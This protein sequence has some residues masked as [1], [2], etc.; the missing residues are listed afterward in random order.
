MGVNLDQ[1]HRERQGIHMGHQKGFSCGRHK[2]GGVNQ[3]NDV[4]ARVFQVAEIPSVNWRFFR[5]GLG[6]W[7]HGKLVGVGGATDCLEKQVLHPIVAI[8]AAARAR[9]AAV[10]PGVVERLTGEVHHVGVVGCPLRIG[11]GG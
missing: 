5:L 9:I 10:K 2:L 1:S 3:L 7:R 6:W 11:V 4:L 8:H